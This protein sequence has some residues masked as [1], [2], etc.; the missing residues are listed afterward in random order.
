[1][2]NVYVVAATWQSKICMPYPK[3]IRRN[4][5]QDYGRM[6]TAPCKHALP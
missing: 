6:F 1:V 4:S 3:V 2:E 5:F